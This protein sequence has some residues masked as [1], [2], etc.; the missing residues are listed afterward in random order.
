MMNSLNNKII[1]TVSQY[2]GISLVGL[3]LLGLGYYLGHNRQA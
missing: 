2:W 3:G 1:S